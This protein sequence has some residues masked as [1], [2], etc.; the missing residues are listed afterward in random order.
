MALW[1]CG[2]EKTELT[3]LAAASLA[4]VCADIEASYEAKNDIDLIFA[5]GG[6]GT[7]QTQ[8]EEGAPGDLFISAGRSQMEALEAKGLLTEESPVELLENQLVL[9]APKGN[10]AGVKGFED[11]AEDKVRL[12]GL[13]EPKSVPA[14]QYSEETLRNLGLYESVKN[15]AVY[16]SDVRAVL[17]WVE[18]GAVDC[19]LVYATDAYASDKTEVICPAPQGYGR[20][21]IYPAAAIKG[22]PCEKEA[23]EFMEFLQGKEA[24]EIFKKYGFKV[25]K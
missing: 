9:I 21:V 7:L 1:G 11:L 8:I 10:P 13:G 16:G 12:I 20:P 3:V 2:A 6:S 19:G 24:A 23:L 18:E 4:D 15:K 5:Y 25:I 17:S 14:G 22:S